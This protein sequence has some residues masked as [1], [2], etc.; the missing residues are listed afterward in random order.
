MPATPD[1]PE[2]A[3]DPSAPDARQSPRVVLGFDFGRTRIGVA[4]GV[5]ITGTARPLRVLP[6]CRQHPDWDAIDRL[7]AEWR[8]DLLVVGVPRHADGSAN[9]MTV[10]ALRF[11]R[12]LHGR[13]HLPV[14]TI[15]E[16]LSSW[17]A[18]QRSFEPAVGRRRGDGAALD[19]RAAALI[20]ESWFNQQRSLA[21][22]ATPNS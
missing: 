15:D 8:P 2:P 10:A 16:R 22:C 9:A 19:D 17:E 3:A 6:A 1:P 20:L 18:E 14:A 4:T 5:T 7:L 11:S 12:Q 13:F 21:S